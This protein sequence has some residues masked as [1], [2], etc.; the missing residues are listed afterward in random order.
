M[1]N[2]FILVISAP[3][4][5][6]GG[7]WHQTKP[8]GCEVFNTYP[9]SNEY[10]I[11]DGGCKDGKVDGEG[12]LSWYLDNKLFSTFKGHLKEGKKSGKGVFE[13]ANLGVFEGIWREHIY[14]DNATFRN[15]SCTTYGNFVNYKAFGNVVTQCKDGSEYKGEVKDSKKYGFGEMKL[16]NSRKQEINDILLK[17]AGKYIDDFFVVSGL[18]EDDRL[19]VECAT[20]KECS[21]R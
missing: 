17:K 3:I 16:H 20:K 14:M 9:V 19:L 5:L 7:E 13:V 1:K 15:T 4:F 10:V 12:T 21:K 6:F 8:S 2:F 18:W 11:W